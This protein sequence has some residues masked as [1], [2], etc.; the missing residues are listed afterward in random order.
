MVLDTNVIVSAV[1]YGGV[2]ANVVRLVVR[3]DVIG[4]T[5]N[6]LIA[7]TLEILTKKIGFSRQRADAIRRKVRR[8]FRAMHPSRKLSVLRDDA[9]NRVLEAAVAGQCRYIV[10]GDKELLDLT[11]YRDIQ[12]VTPRQFIDLVA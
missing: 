9:D 7:E 10:T 5:S 3:G 12:I 1:A 4:V 8:N 6:I 11:S 2:P